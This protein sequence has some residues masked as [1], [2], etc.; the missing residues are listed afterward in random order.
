MGCNIYEYNGISIAISED[1]NDVPCLCTF[2]HNNRGKI[3]KYQIQTMALL[4]ATIVM[5]HNRQLGAKRG[6]LIYIPDCLP[7]WIIKEIIK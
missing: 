6:D 3:D 7:G 2:P 1:N 5:I 4:G